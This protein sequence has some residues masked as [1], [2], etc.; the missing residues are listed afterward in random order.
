MRIHH[1]RW[2]HSIQHSSFNLR[3]ENRHILRNR[4]PLI[5]RGL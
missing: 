3:T 2:H 1:M 4:L 5:V